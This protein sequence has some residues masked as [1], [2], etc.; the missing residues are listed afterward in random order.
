MGLPKGNRIRYVPLTHRVAAALHGYRH[1]RGRACS[2]ERDGR[3]LTQ[4]VLQ[5]IVRAAA[6]RAG[7][8]HEGLH[9]LRHTFCSHLAMRSAPAQSYSGVGGAQGPEH[10]AAVN[11]PQSGSHQGT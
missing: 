7:L 1:L 11:A 10:D 5:C 9:V 2:D 4:K 6:R 8:K 3:P